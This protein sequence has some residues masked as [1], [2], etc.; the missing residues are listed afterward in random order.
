MDKKTIL[1]VGLI[2]LAVLGFLAV[3]G[4]SKKNKAAADLKAQEDAKA[5]ADAKVRADA[6]EKKRQEDLARMND[7]E[8]KKLYDDI[9]LGLI[10][11][12]TDKINDNYQRMKEFGI[13]NNTEE[14]LA[15]LENL[16]RGE[17]IE[18]KGNA[19]KWWNENLNTF[20]QMSIDEIN[21]FLMAMKD[22]MSIQ[23]DPFLFRQAQEFITKYPNLNL[24]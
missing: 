13:K 4:K 17:L 12:I 3:S 10:K 24:E 21:F 23:N 6:A 19:L 1:V 15:Q 9:Y 8:R 18:V 7:P 16:H 2:G 5:Q 22:P 11:F 14:G 20:N